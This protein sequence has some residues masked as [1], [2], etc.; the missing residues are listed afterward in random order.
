MILVQ[1]QAHLLSHKLQRNTKTEYQPN[2]EKKLDAAFGEITPQRLYALTG[3]SEAHLLEVVSLEAFET[4][5]HARVCLYALSY[6]SKFR[7]KR[8][9][10]SVCPKTS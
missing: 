7:N 4:A 9:F 10:N 3:S 8:D 5:Q 2:S 6:L 1:L